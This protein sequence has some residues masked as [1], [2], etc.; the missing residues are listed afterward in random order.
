MIQTPRK[1]ILY[2]YMNSSRRENFIQIKARARYSVLMSA[3]TGH[4][5]VS[6]KNSEYPLM[7]LFGKT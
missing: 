7:P 4:V 3:E 2:E 5:Y 6:C 1:L